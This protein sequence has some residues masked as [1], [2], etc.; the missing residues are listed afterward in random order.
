MK[1]HQFEQ[2]IKNAKLMHKNNHL[3]TCFK[4]GILTWHV[5]PDQKT[6][7][8][9]WWDD[10]EFIVNDYRVSV[11]WC[12]PRQAFREFIEREAIEMVVKDYPE[13]PIGNEMLELK[14]KPIFKKIGRSRKKV[15]WFECTPIAENDFLERV[16]EKE[17]E[18]EVSTDFHA[19]PSFDITWAKRSRLVVA[20]IPIEIHNESDLIT[21]ASIIRRLIKRDT[22]INDLFPQYRYTRSEWK[23]EEQS[24]GMNEFHVHLIR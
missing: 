8:L 15:K 23:N 20:C 4:N 18:I 5:Y 1:T 16:R 11:V 17:R 6:D 19:K 21:L 24:R 12:H 14:Q 2:R 3:Q 10:F 7:S 9:S 22:T 13:L